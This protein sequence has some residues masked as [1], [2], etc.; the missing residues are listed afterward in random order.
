MKVTIFDVANWFL[1]KES[2]TPKKLQKLCWYAYSWFIFLNNEEAMSIE[3]ELFTAEFQAWVHGPVN[4]E[5]YSK[6]R[7]FG[8]DF[9]PQMNE[10]ETSLDN[11]E[12]VVI[13]IFLEEIYRVYGAY[14]AD[15]LESITHQELPWQRAR[16]GLAYHEP[17]NK[18]ISNIDVFEEYANRS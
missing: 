3:S 10:V 6:Y 4:P 11:P 5:L 14:S 13:R 7:E 9:I 16:V 2:M 15:Q 17:T 8:Y 1:T 12:T 18:I